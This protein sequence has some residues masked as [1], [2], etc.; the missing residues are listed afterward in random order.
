MEGRAKVGPKFCRW[1]LAGLAALVAVALVFPAGVARAAPLIAVSPSIG[2]PGTRV[3]LSG[4][5][6]DSYRGDSLSIFFGVQEIAGSPVT[7]PITGRFEVGLDV[8]DDAPPGQVAITVRSDIGAILAQV[9]FTV[10]APSITLE[11][12]VAAVGE[13]VTATGS[14][15]H[16]GKI[17]SFYLGYDSSRL[18]LGT[19]EADA[20]GQFRYEFVVQP[21]PG[22]QRQVIAED[23]YGHVALAPLSVLATAEIEPEEAPAG[24]SVLVRGGGFAG[25]SRVT[26]LLDTRR[27]GTATSDEMGSFEAELVVPNLASGE[28]DFRVMDAMGNGIRLTF[29]LVPGAEV[30]PVTGAVGDEV[31]VSAT[32]F[33]PYGEVT[34]SYDATTV[35]TV[36]ADGSGAFETSFHV[37]VS[38][39]GDHTIRLSDGVR[40]VERLFT[41]ESVPPVTPPLVLP[42][43]GAELK[44]PLS[45]SWAGVTDASQPVTYNLQIARDEAFQDIVLEKAGL[46]FP[47]YSVPREED[48]RPNR[49][50]EVYYW[51]VQAVDGAGNT[52]QWSA[53][54]TFSV[55]RSSILPLWAIW[56]LAAAGVLIVAFLV[57]RLTR[58]TRYMRNYWDPSDT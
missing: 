29:R 48:L 53:V 32:G 41:V 16:A 57:F 26:L 52:S 31:T 27:V 49:R 28:Y 47:G 14:G 46:S 42:E 22:G 45:F 12:E 18:K 11:L 20:T 8:P 35:A 40:L 30:S 23:G 33:E 5:N 36:T 37:P 15:F 7:V 13:V 25:A 9:I 51:R 44:S 55:L 2:G 17:M 54:G 21:V 56:V 43:E 3:T 19:A 24:T 34:I 1:R 38:L 39:H 4:S 6:F 10:P 50:G 58:E